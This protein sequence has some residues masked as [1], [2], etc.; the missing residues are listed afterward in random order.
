[1]CSFLASKFP[2]GAIHAL[3][4]LVLQFIVVIVGIPKTFLSLP[5]PATIF[6]FLFP[7]YFFLD[8]L[9]ARDVQIEPCFRFFLVFDDFYARALAM[10]AFTIFPINSLGSLQSWW[11]LLLY[12]EGFPVRMV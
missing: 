12:N 8:G 1:M 7:D 10:I 11:F 3:C 2:N 6:T 9:N 5:R 4:W